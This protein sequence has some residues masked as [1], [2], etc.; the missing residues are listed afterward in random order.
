[1]PIIGKITEI[2]T[3]RYF[4]PNFSA[5]GRASAPVS[6]AYAMIMACGERLGTR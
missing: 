6:D 3:K 2:E 1:M 5:I 4:A